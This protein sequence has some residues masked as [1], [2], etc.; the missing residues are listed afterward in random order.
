MLISFRLIHFFNI[1]FFSILQ[2]KNII[3]YAIRIEN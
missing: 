2:F 3:N 1:I